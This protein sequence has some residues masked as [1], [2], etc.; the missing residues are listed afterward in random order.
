MSH[1][2]FSGSSQL[3]Q[4]LSIEAMCKHQALL[5]MSHSRVFCQTAEMEAAVFDLAMFACCITVCPKVV[6]VDVLAEMPQRV[7]APL[8]NSFGALAPC[9][10]GAVVRFKVVVGIKCNQQTPWKA[11]VRVVQIARLMKGYTMLS[12]IQRGNAG[13]S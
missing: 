13:S 6:L 3:D 1:S 2:K 7:A 5:A 10:G 9:C 11:Y 4:R 8:L 12:T